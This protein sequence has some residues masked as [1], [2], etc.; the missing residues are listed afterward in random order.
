[1][2]DL[3]VDE[4]NATLLPIDG[5][6]HLLLHHVLYNRKWSASDHVAFLPSDHV[7]FLT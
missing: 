6:A 5:K 3:V 7:A 2:N 1:M 4:D